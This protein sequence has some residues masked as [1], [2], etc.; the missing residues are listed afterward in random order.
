MPGGLKTVVRRIRGMAGLPAVHECSDRQLLERFANIGEQAAF[1]AL[2]ERHGPLV[3]G[4][5]RRV[6]RNTEDAEDA[7]QAT[8]MVLAKKAGSDFWQNS[9]SNWLHGVAHRV[10]LKTRTQRLRQ[11]QRDL[12]YQPAEATGDNPTDQMT[13]GELRSVLDS[14]LARLPARYRAPLLLCYL[15]GKTRDE[16]AA[17]LG[18]SAGSVKGRLERGRDLLRRRLARRGLTISAALCASLLPETAG[19]MPA[20]LA[21][22]T[23]QAATGFATGTAVGVSAQTLS[24]AQGIMQALLLTRIKIAAVLLIGVSVMSVAAVATHQAFSDAPRT[25]PPVAE[26]NVVQQPAEPAPPTDAAPETMPPVEDALPTKQRGQVVSVTPRKS[27]L[28]VRVG[29]NKN[30]R[31]LACK[32]DEAT[33]FF[34]NEQ[35]AELGLADIP[36][37]SQVALQLAADGAT[38]THLHVTVPT[39]SGVLDELDVD[40]GTLTLREGKADPRVY[41]LAANTLL[42]IG[43]RPVAASA[44]QPGTRVTLQLSLDRSQVLSVTAFPRERP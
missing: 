14:E 21:A 29:V 6:L 30:V 4:V 20:H 42:R 40:N 16:A 32:V 1:A 44:L 22:A 23:L 3:L 37:G 13:W 33:Q 26:A 19:A 24:L 11:R 18:W 41:D 9:I 36:P 35:P 2:V 10:A 38:I 17:Q 43:E 39:A 34:L 25:T 12:T 31:L 28:E 8:F 7:F 5:C 27:A 15:E